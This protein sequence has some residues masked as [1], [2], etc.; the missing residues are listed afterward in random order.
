MAAR[1]LACNV[2]MHDA[3]TIPVYTTHNAA[4]GVVHDAV[5]TLPR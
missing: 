1:C 4:A 3:G 5:I 2:Y